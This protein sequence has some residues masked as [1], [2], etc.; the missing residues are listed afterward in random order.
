MSEPMTEEQLQELLYAGTANTSLQRA[1]EL[2]KKQAEMMREGAG[3]PEGQMISGRYVA[4]HFLQYAG[5]MARQ[6]AAHK[7]DQRAQNTGMEIDN[8]MSKQNQAVLAA[9]LRGRAGTG[10]TP[11]F[12]PGYT[13]PYS[14]VQ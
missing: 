10:I 6:Y 13:T 11:P 7:M 2:Q 14:G 3:A 4:P 5:N 1:L 12:N 8:N 9:I